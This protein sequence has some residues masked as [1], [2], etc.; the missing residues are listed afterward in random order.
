MKL[1]TTTRTTGHVCGA[2]AIGAFG[3][4]GA[5]KPESARLRGG[6]AQRVFIPRAAGVVDHNWTGV[7]V[8]GGLSRS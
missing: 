2:P 4:A 5:M 6:G 3:A 8:P 1:Y 7:S